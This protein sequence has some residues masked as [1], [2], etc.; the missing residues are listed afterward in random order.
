MPTNKNKSNKKKGRATTT[1]GNTTF[2]PPTPIKNVEDAVKNMKQLLN[3]AALINSADNE[4]EKKYYQSIESMLEKHLRAEFDKGTYHNVFDS[5]KK[6]VSGSGKGI[7]ALL[8]AADIPLKIGMSVVNKLRRVNQ[9]DNEDAWDL[10]GVDDLEKMCPEDSE[11]VQDIKSAMPPSMNYYS[12]KEGERTLLI[13]CQIVELMIASCHVTSTGVAGERF[14]MWPSKAIQKLTT[15]TPSHEFSAEDIAFFDGIDKDDIDNLFLLLFT[16]STYKSN[17]HTRRENGDEALVRLLPKQP[18]EKFVQL[19]MSHRALG[20][21]TVPNHVDAVEESVRQEQIQ[22]IIN[23]ELRPLLERAKQEKTDHG[24]VSDEIKEEL[25]QTL[26]PINRES[27]DYSHYKEPELQ[28]IAEG[29]MEKLPA[30]IEQVKSSSQGRIIVWE[31]CMYDA[32]RKYKGDELDTLI[33]PECSEFA[34]VFEGTDKLLRITTTQPGGKVIKHL[35]VRSFH[36]IFGEEKTMKQRISTIDAYLGAISYICAGGIVTK[37][38]AESEARVMQ[39]FLMECQGFNGD[40]FNDDADGS[41]NYARQHAVSE[42]QCVGGCI[43]N[44]RSVVTL[45]K[46]GYLETLDIYSQLGDDQFGLLLEAHGITDGRNNPMNES[47]ACQGVMAAGSLKARLCPYDREDMPCVHVVGVNIEDWAL[48]FKFGC[49]HCAMSIYNR[50]VETIGQCIE[51]KETAT[52]AQQKRY[53]SN[54]RIKSKEVTRLKRQEVEGKIPLTAEEKKS[55]EKRKLKEA[56]QRARKKQEAN[57]KQAVKSKEVI[58]L[59]KREEE[60]EKLASPKKKRAEKRKQSNAKQTAKNKEVTALPE[61][62]ADDKPTSKRSKEV[63]ALKKRAESTQWSKDEDALL[64]RLVTSA[65]YQK[66]GKPDYTKIA[67]KV[68]GRT[69]KQVNER[70]TNVLNPKLDKSP[71]DNADDICLWKAYKTLGKDFARISRED[72]K[73]KRSPNQV[74]NRFN[75]A[76]FKKFVAENDDKDAYENAF[77]EGTYD[78]VVKK[79]RVRDPKSCAKSKEVTKL[80]RQKAEGKIPLTAEEEA[81]VEKWRM[82]SRGAFS[83][84]SLLLAGING[85][86]FLNSMYLPGQRDKSKAMPLPI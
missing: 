9:Q 65:D 4:E 83:V 73:G 12:D 47:F 67:T 56:K 78:K 63:T 85:K 69:G 41:F 3:T 8:R 64:T 1:T 32:A 40:I 21:G 22:T 60:G 72:F 81:R 36:P 80:K 59:K 79:S 26:E 42:G 37:E 49:H 76:A 5:V 77:G 20:I 82:D 52:E 6:L 45:L 16:W 27:G 57:A 61:K 74:K 19:E 31:R 54:S 15:L 38:Y 43:K 55:V 68:E 30:Y 51:A 70:W 10:A 44:V 62:R 23:N 50:E 14:M 18:D 84:E 39:T 46:I 53:K 29:A 24:V 58:A 86:V 17:L 35:I 13:Q 34:E 28:A 66:N 7:Y 71:F 33:P 25:R 48:P 11:V 75:G 2:E